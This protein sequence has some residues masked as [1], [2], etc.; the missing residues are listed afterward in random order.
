VSNRFNQVYCGADCKTYMLNHR[1]IEKHR[2]TNRRVSPPQHVIAKRAA[3]IRAAR[4][5][6]RQSQPYA[7][8]K[9]GAGWERY[10]VKL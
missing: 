4:L 10:K 9:T 3:A 1:R 8:R 5:A 7:G 2:T 6:E